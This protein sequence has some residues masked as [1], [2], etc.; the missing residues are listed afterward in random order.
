MY[1]KFYRPGNQY[2]GKYKPYR[3]EPAFWRLVKGFNER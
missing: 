1:W 3:A 2:I